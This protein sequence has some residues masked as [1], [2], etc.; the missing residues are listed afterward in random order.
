MSRLSPGCLHPLLL[1]AITFCLVICHGAPPVSSAGGI[2][3]H[4]I[5][6]GSTGRSCQLTHQI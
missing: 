6:K 1:D 4:E 2:L 3:S 5:M